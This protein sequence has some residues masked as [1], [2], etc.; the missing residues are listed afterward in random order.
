MH[1]KIITAFDIQT[2]EELDYLYNELSDNIKIVKI[3]MEAFYTFGV[4][5]IER[6]KDKN[7]NIF[8]DLKLHDIPTTVFKAA[9]TLG[10]LGVDILNVHAAGGTDMMKAGLEGFLDSNPN[11]KLIGVTQLTSTN[12]DIMNNELNISGSL[13][14]QV[15]RMAYL[16][17]NA[18]LHGIVCSAGEV[19][20][21]K[22]E[23]G[24]SFLCITPG[25]RP[26]GSASDDQKRI[27]TPEEALAFGADYL[28]IGRPITKATSPRKAYSEIIKGL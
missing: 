14:E 5:I 27:Y 1:E 6:F 19:R 16:V 23:L 8:L 3:G 4:P 15:K 2:R 7:I 22:S 11:G 9:K 20:S 10:Q 24:A 13:E 17:K 25:I 28:V 21:I 12:Q 26:R 18:G